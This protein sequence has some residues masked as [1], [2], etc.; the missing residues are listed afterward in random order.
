MTDHKHS[1]LEEIMSKFVNVFCRDDDQ[2]EKLLDPDVINYI[3]NAEGGVDKVQGREALM[4][5]IRSMNTVG[6]QFSLTITQMVTIKPEQ[7]LMM[8]EIKADRGEKTLHNFAA[9]L[10]DIKDNH[11]RQMRMVEAFP[12][13]S[14]EFWK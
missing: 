14:D 8:V 6:V 13:Y 2:M 7:G 4:K 10:I 3:T 5:R 12:A 1:S 11:I 9:F